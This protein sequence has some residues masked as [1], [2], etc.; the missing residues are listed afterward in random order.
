MKSGGLRFWIA[1]GLGSGFVPF[2]P[3]TAGSALAVGLFW[4]TTR[5]GVVWL[6]ALTFAALVLAGF[7]SAGETARRPSA[8][9][10]VLW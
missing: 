9:H 2:A 6:P 4:L 3:G 5:P 1:T 8:H 10:P 7:W